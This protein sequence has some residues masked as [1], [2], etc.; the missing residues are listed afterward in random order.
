MGPNPMGHGD[1]QRERTGDTGRKVAI[2]TPGRAARSRA[3][4]QP[5]GGGS[6]PDTGSH[7]PTD[8]SSLPTS[9]L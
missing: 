8:A 1:T 4:P 9:R 2:Y 7:F 6:P 3:F 5:S